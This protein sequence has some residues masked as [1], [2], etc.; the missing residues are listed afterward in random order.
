VIV[1]DSGI[2]IAALIEEGPRG[3]FAAERLAREPVHVP[4]VLDSEVI[5]VLR[6]MVVVQQVLSAERGEAALIDLSE[7]SVTR[8]PH[9]GLLPRAW[10][11]RENIRS[12]DAMYVALAETLNTL[13]LTADRRLA[14]AR[15]VRCQI[16]VL[17]TE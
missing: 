3:E 4:H 15:G 16:E 17:G 5:G 12:Y 11:L 6:R 8:Y 9:V 2:V 1:I 10:E 14:N 7:L 13:L